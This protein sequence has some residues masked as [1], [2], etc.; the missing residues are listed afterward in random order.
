MDIVCKGNCA[1]CP[2]AREKGEKAEKCI[3]V[4]VVGIGFDVPDETV[5][6]RDYSI[7][8]IGLREISGILDIEPDI[9][10][11]LV[12]ALRLEDTLYPVTKLIDMDL[13]VIS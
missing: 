10:L 5:H 8:F 7:N 11:D 1:A 13:K 3:K 2:L 4:A 9:V 12:D 6:F